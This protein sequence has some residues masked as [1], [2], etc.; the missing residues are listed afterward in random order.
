[1]RLDGASL[2]VHARSARQG[3][4]GRRDGKR[5]ARGEQ[6]SDH[7]S[8]EDREH[9]R[10]RACVGTSPCPATALAASGR[11]SGRARAAAALSYSR[12][13]ARSRR[14]TAIALGAAIGA[15]LALWALFTYGGDE[16][17]GGSG[18]EAPPVDVQI[19]PASRADLLAGQPLT[20]R[21]RHAAGG[22]VRLEVLLRQPR[23][24][25]AELSPP[26]EVALPARDPQTVT[27]LPSGPARATLLGCDADRIDVRATDRRFPR[28][29]IFTTRI[30]LDP[31]DCR[32]FFGPKAVWNTPLPPDAPTDPDSAAITA[33]LRKQVR[34]GFHS[35]LPPTINTTSYAPPVYTVGSGQPRVPVALD[36]PPDYDPGFAAAFAAGVPIP[37]GAQ[38]A[39]GADSELVIWQPSTDTMWE[40]WQARQAP[41]GWHASWGGR[42]EHISTGPGHFA[43]PHAN[44]GTAASSLPLVGGLILPRELQS[45]RIDHALSIAIPETRK[46]EFSLPA[47]RTDGRSGCAQSVPEG[48]R[49]RLDP[50]L[51]VSALGLP[52]VTTALARAAQRYGIFVRDQSGAVAFF[53]QNPLS[54][55]SDPYPAI[56]GGKSP[57]DLL[58][59]FPWSR[60]QLVRMQLAEANGPD[61]PVRGRAAPLAPCR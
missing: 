12:P 49:F 59:D 22:T 21:L 9:Q 6:R 4:A 43:A 44:W 42:L 48:A 51:D 26:R 28:A 47:Q 31:P 52:P 57:T 13:I 27:M 40:L 37:A 29:R 39:A 53:A 38:P 54:L 58:R 7:R 3:G 2:R 46:E 41:E 45:G 18:G 15:L 20:L 17:H 35:K 23:G 1:M 34:N 32:R 8:A 19:A 33:V 11:L 14:N 61:A 10:V 25:A 55:P 60:L 16:R 30:R 50:A 24:G 56:F 5:R 36:R